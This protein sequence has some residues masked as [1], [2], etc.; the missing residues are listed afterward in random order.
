MRSRY[1]L[2]KRYSHPYRRRRSRRFRKNL[3]PSLLTLLRRRNCGISRKRRN[4]DPTRLASFRR[5]NTFDPRRLTSLRR[6]NRFDPTRLTTLRRRDRFASRRRY[7]NPV[8][9]GSRRPL[10]RE[11]WY[12]RTPRSTETRLAQRRENLFKSRHSGFLSPNRV[13]LRRGHRSP[14]LRRNPDPSGKPWG[15]ELYNP[16]EDSK[17][18]FKNDRHYHK[19]IAKLRRNPW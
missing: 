15:P 8:Q 5:R 14:S 12:S 16:L 13:F 2:R 3:D 11:D 17:N 19:M 7:R 18:K 9:Y 4:F 6:R 1:G 10:K